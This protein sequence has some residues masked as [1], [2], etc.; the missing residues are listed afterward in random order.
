MRLRECMDLYE[1]RTGLRVT[2]SDLAERTGLSLPTI[3]S[4][5]SREHYNATLEAVERLCVALGVTP[6]EL[7]EWSDEPSLL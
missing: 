7:L 6:N 2:Y 1:A 4:V 3:Q 5:G